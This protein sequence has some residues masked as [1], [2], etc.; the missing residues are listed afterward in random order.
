MT[1]NL[2]NPSPTLLP[3]N[4]CSSFQKIFKL[5]LD[6]KKHPVKK[7]NTVDQPSK[8]SQQRGFPY[9]YLFTH[10]DLSVAVSI[11]LVQPQ[12]K[13]KLFS[14][15][16]NSSTS[17]KLITMYLT[18]SLFRIVA[19]TLVVLVIFPCTTQAVVC[20]GLDTNGDGI[21]EDCI[22]CPTGKFINATQGAYNCQPCSALAFSATQG[23]SS[24]T[25]CL[26][27]CSAGEK[28]TTACS[29]TTN[30][31]CESCALG[32]YQNEQ[33]AASSC[34]NCSTTPLHCGAGEKLATC[35]SQT[36][37]VCEA[38]DVGYFQSSTL[39]QLSSCTIHTKCE[40]GKYVNLNVTASRDR[41]CAA[42]SS[43]KFSS[44]AL[45]A[46]T[47]PWYGA[48]AIKNGGVGACSNCPAGCEFFCCIFLFLLQTVVEQET[49]PF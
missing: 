22:G 8:L 24:C 28:Q 9:R 48:A 26:A 30:R 29:S 31:V 34:K 23:A 33:A 20:T 6:G 4:H 39:H 10:L 27:S 36:N 2:Q 41:F 43:G 14:N 47:Y 32:L 46:D 21:D 37:R 49:D 7:K 3:K 16:F 11:Y 18:N 17:N 35:T 44:V 42:C 40:A 25:P 15:K 13:K 12:K 5:R 38:C 1:S 19:C 45:I